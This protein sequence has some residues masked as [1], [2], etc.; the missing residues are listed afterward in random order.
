MPIRLLGTLCLLVI[1]GILSLGLW[2]FYS[3]ANGVAWLGATH[4]IGFSGEGF[5]FSKV[6]LP[7]GGAGYSVEIW[8][9]PSKNG[10]GSTLLTLRNPASADCPEV[11]LQ[12]S[13]K[14][15]KIQSRREQ[16]YFQ[17]PKRTLYVDNMFEAR[18]QLFLTITSGAQGTRVYANGNLFQAFPSEAIFACP[19][20]GAIILGDAAGQSDGWSGRIFGLGTYQAE[21]TGEQ[22][23]RHFESWTKS[24]QP[25]LTAQDKNQTLYLLDEGKGRTA[26]D[27]GAGAWDLEMP[28]QYSVIGKKTLPGFWDEFT[29]TPGYWQ[30][31]ANN[32]VGFIPVG[33]C[34]LAYFSNATS[35]RRPL[36][37][38][39]LSGIALSLTIECTQPFLAT[40]ESGTTDLVTNTTGTLFGVSLYSPLTRWWQQRFHRSLFY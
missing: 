4:G 10:D 7:I 9:T 13:W 37:W 11:G 23:Q 36:L 15:L 38:A 16:S 29:A 26:H 20:Q 8:A 34:F 28:E 18:T 3:P 14:D 22:V 35:L 1:A 2:P 12:R 19:F 30:D 25:H 21:L 17:I 24:G 5:A 32:I 33:F 39:I 6:G 27:Q 31:F 40:R